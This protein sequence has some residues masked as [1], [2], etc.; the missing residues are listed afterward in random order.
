MFI[1]YEGLH[2]IACPTMLDI[3]LHFSVKDN[4]RYCTSMLEA[5]RVIYL[6]VH[7]LGTPET[8]S[9]QQ[10]HHTYP[11]RKGIEQHMQ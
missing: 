3:A 6:L 4:V 7:D 1:K 5:Y 11:R 9:Q 8:Q 2:G 10:P